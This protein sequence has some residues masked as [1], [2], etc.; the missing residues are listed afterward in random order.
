MDKQYSVKQIE[1]AIHIVGGE[2]EMEDVIVELERA[3]KNSFIHADSRSLTPGEVPAWE[4]DKA[5][6]EVAV[7]VLS[8]IHEG[9]SD[10]DGISAEMEQA[11]NALAKIKELTVLQ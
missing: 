1:A 10:D 6:L 4:R 7:R 9:Y 5:G 2:F 3:K 8:T 11:G